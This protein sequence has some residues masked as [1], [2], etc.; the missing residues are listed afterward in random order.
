VTITGAA[1]SMSIAASPAT[2]PGT[3]FV[4]EG[5]VSAA[6]TVTVRVCNVTG[7]ALTPASS[8]YNVRVIQ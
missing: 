5:L 1:T 7:G 8:A 6:N 4:W 3:G 2:D